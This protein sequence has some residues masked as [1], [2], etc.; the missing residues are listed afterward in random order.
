LA[1]NLGKPDYI[2]RGLLKEHRSLFKAYWEGSQSTMDNA[3][4]KGVLYTKLGWRM[5]RA[6][7]PNPRA[8]I[9][10][11][12]QGNGADM[13]K[14]ACCLGTERGVQI[15]APIHDATLIMAP[16]DQLEES[17]AKMRAAWA[18]ASRVIL[19][20]FEIRTDAKLIRYPDRYSDKRGAKTW[21]KLMELLEEEENGC[22]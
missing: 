18:E 13:L 16:I 17:V 1:I 2:A 20:G 11:P 8:L 10:F 7:I 5:L 21:A 15:C 9:N 19:D 14:L 3:A 4:R 12:M 6:K 22:V